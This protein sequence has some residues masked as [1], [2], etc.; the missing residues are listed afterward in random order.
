[1][2]DADSSS[3]ERSATSNRARKRPRGWDL[4]STPEVATNKDKNFDSKTPADDLLQKQLQQIEALQQLQSVQPQS[5]APPLTA[6]VA[7]ASA[8][9]IAA[10]QAPSRRIYVGYLI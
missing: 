10:A 1:M 8:A 2:V 9:T 3:I 7:A 5:L 6:A 4:D